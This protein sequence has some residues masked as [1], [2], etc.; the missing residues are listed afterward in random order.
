M[1][2]I[3]V[4]RK[5]L[6]GNNIIPSCEYCQREKDV[7]FKEKCLR[8]KENISEEKCKYF[9]YNPLKRIPIKGKNF[10]KNIYNDEDFQL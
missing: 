3:S 2:F 4:K 10:R 5:K 6:F 7:N 8:S 1:K 9:V